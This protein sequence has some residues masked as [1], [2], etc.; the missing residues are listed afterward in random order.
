MICQR[1]KKYMSHW[2]GWLSHKEIVEVNPLEYHHFV[3]FFFR[4][5]VE[6][7][8]QDL[9]GRILRQLKYTT[10]ETHDL[11]KHCLHESS[12]VSCLNDQGLL[13]Q[14]YG[15]PH[16]LLASYRKVARTWSKLK[17]GDTKNSWLF[18]KFLVKYDKVERKHMW[19]AINLIWML[20]PSCPMPW[21]TNGTEQQIIF[22]KEMNED[23]A[24]VI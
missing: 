5:I 3:F 15:D 24:L 9:T 17:F 16:I 8:V 21:L 14:R 11:I 20:V 22:M 18:C 4:E 19:N 7:W 12:Y 10:G 6:K 13:K 2:K 23:Q 1:V